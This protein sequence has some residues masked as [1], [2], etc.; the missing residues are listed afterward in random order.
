MFGNT[1]CCNS[2]A[3]IVDEGNAGVTKKQSSTAKLGC[4]SRNM[5]KSKCAGKPLVLRGHRCQWMIVTHN[6]SVNGRTST[7]TGHLGVGG[8]GLVGGG[9]G[10]GGYLTVAGILDET[11]KAVVTTANVE[12]S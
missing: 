2:A 12:S 5:Q 7:Q 4:C 6:D 8:R 1:Q 3:R 9:P 11:C 10:Q